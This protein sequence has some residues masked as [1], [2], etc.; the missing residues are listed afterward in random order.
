MAWFSFHLETSGPPPI[1]ILWSARSACLRSLLRP[2]TATATPNATATA[3]CRIR[4]PLSFSQTICHRFSKTLSS[5]SVFS[6]GD[7]RVPK[8]TDLERDNL[9]TVPNLL[10]VSRIVLAPYV[11]HLITIGEFEWALGCF[12]YAG[13]SDM[14][15]TNR[16]TKFTKSACL[17]SSFLGCFSWTGWLPGISRARPPWSAASW[18]R[19]PTRSLWRRSSSA[20]P[21][22]TWSRPRWPAWSS[23]GTCSSSTRAATF[24][25]CPWSRP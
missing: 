20:W 4:P 16:H 11:A 15:R 13:T 17:F 14:V 25:T 3:I 7:S 23:R 9:V 6:A 24:D 18:T 22:S 10:C 19:W 1:M 21:T 12:V 8:P 5:S 2:A